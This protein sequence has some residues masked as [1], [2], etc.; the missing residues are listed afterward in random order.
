MEVEVE[1]LVHCQDSEKTAEVSRPRG[2]RTAP[3]L[4]E[5]VGLNAT[6]QP[7]VSV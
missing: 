2:P 4:G 5:S 1:F 7:V 3:S 6:H